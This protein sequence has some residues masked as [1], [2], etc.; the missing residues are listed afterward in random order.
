MENSWRGKLL[1]THKIRPAIITGLIV[2]ALLGSL[3][4][5]GH[6]TAYPVSGNSSWCGLNS[7]VGYVANGPGLGDDQISA[8]TSPQ[9]GSWGCA[10]W[11]CGP[12]QVFGL[13]AHVWDDVGEQRYLCSTAGN[14]WYLGSPCY[15]NT[16]QGWGTLTFDFGAAFHPG[17]Q[18]VEFRMYACW[19]LDCPS[20]YKNDIRLDVYVP[21][22]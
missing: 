17:W 16:N 18:H 22:S 2:P 9:W 6:A 8:N 1:K 20:G 14:G 10:C 15:I 4:V 21:S 7:W 12:P 5:S 3:I 13:W 11:W 19:S